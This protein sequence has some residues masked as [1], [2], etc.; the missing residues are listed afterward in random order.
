MALINTIFDSIFALLSFLPLRIHLI[1]CAVVFGVLLVP[2]Y[3]KVSPQRLIARS[4]KRI[5]AALYESVVFRRNT[6]LSLAAQGKMFW[7]GLI[8][9]LVAI[10]PILILS[11]P[12]V[13]IL[14]QFNSL[15]GVRGA[16]L[17]RPLLVS[18][19]VA[20]SIDVRR[21]TLESSDGLEVSTPVRDPN[22]HEITW[23][24]SAPEALKGKTSA[25]LTLRSGE[26]E[27]PFVFALDGAKGKIYSEN[28]RS[29][30]RQ[31]LYPSGIK[32]PEWLQNL[33]VSYPEMV[34]SYGPIS[35][36]WLVVFLV[37]SILSGYIASKVFGVEV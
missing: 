27:V 22:G 33:Q 35:S 36:G 8:Y 13:F 11:V 1:V 4:K 26:G 30:W 2:V 12:C 37:I 34:F 18:A 32:N 19:E 24:V 9:F 17:N 21:T 14:A 15:Y 10:P 16:Q 28:P 31:L 29:F 20:P 3:G 5:F 7:N 25:T 23:R 6:G